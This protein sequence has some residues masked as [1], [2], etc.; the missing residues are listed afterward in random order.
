MMNTSDKHHLYQIHDALKRRFAYVE[1]EPPT[2]ADRDREI[3]LAFQNAI[4]QIADKDNPLKVLDSN[5]DLPPNLKEKINIAYEMLAA[6][7]TAKGLGTAILKVIIQELVSARDSDTYT[8]E[9]GNEIENNLDTVLDWSLTAN[10]LPQFQGVNKKTLEMFE[11]I[12][13]DNTGSPIDFFEEVNKDPSQLSE[14]SEAW[15]MFVKFV[16]NTDNVS[17][18]DLDLKKQRTQ[19]GR[20]SQEWDEQSSQI[21]FTSNQEK[22]SFAKNLRKLI[23]SEDY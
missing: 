16:K 5:D 4:Y 2:R 9:S 14:Y 20:F 8:A 10:L 21:K 17:E 3:A 12:F 18:E 1:I 19:I 23:E 11:K 15:K 6:I 22:G 13:I 7:R